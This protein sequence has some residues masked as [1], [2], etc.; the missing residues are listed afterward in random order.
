MIQN[1]IIT[2][3]ARTN[4]V[5]VW[6]SAAGTV[7]RNNSFYGNATNGVHDQGSGSTISGNITADPGLINP[8]HDFRLSAGS[9]CIDAGMPI[10]QVTSDYAGLARPS[11]SRHDI[12][13]L[14]YLFGIMAPVN[15]RMLDR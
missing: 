3:H 7:I 5:H 8:P 2:D 13:A 1:N 9:P 10:P 15:L 14:E 12:G 6:S 4:P 11:G